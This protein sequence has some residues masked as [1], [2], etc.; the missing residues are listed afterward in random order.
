MQTRGK[1][2]KWDKKPS[3]LWVYVDPEIAKAIKLL[4]SHKKCSVSKYLA[5]ILKT[6][7]DGE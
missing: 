5:S 3:Q 4:A 2:Q 7:I 1:Y 6:A